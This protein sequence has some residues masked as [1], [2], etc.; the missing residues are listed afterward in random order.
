MIKIYCTS[1]AKSINA[2]DGRSL[3][4]SSLKLNDKSAIYPRDFAYK[5]QFW[6]H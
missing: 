2:Y 3:A 1:N 4:Q 5:S 6:S